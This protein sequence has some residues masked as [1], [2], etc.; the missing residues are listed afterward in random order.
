MPQRGKS[1]R[2]AARQTQMGQNKRRQTKG[3]SGVPMA[4]EPLSEVPE[5]ETTPSLE[6]RDGPLPRPRSSLVQ[7]PAPS[8]APEIRPAVYAYVVP[9]L[10]RIL[11]F[12]SATFA[13]LIVLTFFLR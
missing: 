12:S 9:E 1:R 11:T 4:T 6:G 2:T 7:R 3:P 5:E 10:K 13:T 8:R